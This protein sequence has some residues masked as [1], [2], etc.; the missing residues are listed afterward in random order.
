M[1]FGQHTGYHLDDHTTQ[2]EESAPG[3]KRTL[4]AAMPPFLHQF[5]DNHTTIK[6]AICR[7]N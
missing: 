7:T 5:A 3:G 6:K 2:E 1:L 4:A